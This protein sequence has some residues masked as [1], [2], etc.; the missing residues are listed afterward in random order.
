MKYTVVWLYIIVV[1]GIMGAALDFTK[2][3]LL[4]GNNNSI[5]DYL[6]KNNDEYYFKFVATWCPT[7]KKEL[8]QEN[9]GFSNKKI[10]YIF[11][12]YGRDSKTRVKDFLYKNPQVEPAY[13]DNENILK[14]YF[15]VDKVPFV[16]KIEENINF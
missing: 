8:T 7:C 13:F 12:N 1:T 16:V 9:I 6:V 14:K 5:Q 10:I 15:K 11:G 2:L 3:E 4:A